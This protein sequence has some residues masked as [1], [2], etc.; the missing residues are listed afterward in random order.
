MYEMTVLLCDDSLAVHESL[1]SYL[2]ASGIRVISLYDG[3]HLLDLL[4]HQKIDLVI[5]D[6]M[7]PGKFGTE[8]CREIRETSDVPI[9]MLSA[10]SEED[11]RV[12]G[13]ELGADDYVTKPFSPREITARIHTILK[14]T[15]PRR[16]DS[17]L[18]FS[19][20]VLYPSSYQAL[21]SGQALDLTPK[22]FSVLK[23]LAENPGRVLSRD[24]ILD[25]VWGS[26]YFGD[27][28]AVDTIVKRLRGKL[29]KAR[30]CFVIQ[31]IYGVGY[32]LEK[33]EVADQT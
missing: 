9:L 11:D 13:L 14:R 15:Q 33:E 29:A 32:R 12:L 30:A 22:E 7:L 25:R 4:R 21:V 18:F 27:T 20:L 1:S 31:S 23:C 8:L 19:N 2:T 10:R 24:A 5:L 28:R 26:D 3:S 16:P 6:V 17:T